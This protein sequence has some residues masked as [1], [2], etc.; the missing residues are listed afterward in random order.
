MKTEKILNEADLLEAISI[1][2]EVELY[3][4]SKLK[5]KKNK[6]RKLEL[7]ESQKHQII[8]IDQSDEYIFFG[9]IYPP[10]LF[11]QEKLK[12]MFKN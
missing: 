11:L 8:L 7:A 2:F 10:D 1:Y 12:F 9:S 5:I 4:D 6:A 3:H